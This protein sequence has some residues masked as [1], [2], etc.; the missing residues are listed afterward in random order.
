MSDTGTCDS[1]SLTGTRGG[2][3][4][5][6]VEEAARRLAV[7]PAAVHVFVRLRLLRATSDDPPQLWA[8]DVERLRRELLHRG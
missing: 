1:I 4:R 3:R 7:E 5:L 6:S 8:C 2:G